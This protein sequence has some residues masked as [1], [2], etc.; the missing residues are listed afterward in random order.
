MGKKG[1]D[2][3]GVEIRQ[4]NV[5]HKV[6]E[7][8]KCGTVSKRH[9]FGHKWIRD[10]GIEGP[11]VLEVRYSKHFCKKC[12]YYFA[13]P[14]EHL[15]PSNIKYSQRVIRTTLGLVK[16]G[17]SLK[18]ASDIMQSKYHVYVPASTIHDWT[19]KEI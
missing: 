17:A 18:A 19:V 7:C 14:T 13:V 12:E 10:V 3:G 9:S 11:V 16:S 15:A 5:T 2:L 1:I 8:L 4:I 6:Y